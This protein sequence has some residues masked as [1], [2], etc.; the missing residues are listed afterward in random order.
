M[1]LLSGSGIV[2]E[3]FVTVQAL[4]SGLLGVLVIAEL[5]L[6]IGG[7]AE[8]ACLGDTH[9]HGRLHGRLGPA[10]VGGGHFVCDDGIQVTCVRG[11]A[12]ISL[13]FH[14]ALLDLGRHIDWL[15]DR[16]LALLLRPKKLIE[17][18]DVRGVFCSP[19]SEKW[20]LA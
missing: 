8:R 18:Q 17:V 2:S 7:A 14:D 13:W 5:E 12:A 15:I 1:L 16:G 6:G 20:H 11:D 4:V 10:H 9:V 3:E 19:R